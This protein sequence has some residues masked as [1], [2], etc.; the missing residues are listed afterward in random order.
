MIFDL[1]CGAGLAE[2]GGHGVDERVEA[3]VA[4]DEAVDEAAGV[5]AGSPRSAL[6][7]PASRR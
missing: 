3:G 1:L 4:I 6:P 2:I 5:A 7:R